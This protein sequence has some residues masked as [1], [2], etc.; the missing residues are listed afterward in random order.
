MALALIGAYP[1][2]STNAAIVLAQL[3]PLD[4]RAQEMAFR[5]YLT[6]QPFIPRSSLWIIK[7]NVEPF[8]AV[9][10]IQADPSCKLSLP[11]WRNVPFQVALTWKNPIKLCPHSNSTLHIFTDGSKSASKVGYAAIILNSTSIHSPISGRLPGYS[12]P[13]DAEASALTEALLFINHQVHTRDQICISS[14][15]LAI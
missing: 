15:R 12:P 1:T 3:L 13:Y 11:P 4:V 8:E 5:F 10:P 14:Y 7:H 6:H 2:V 9:H